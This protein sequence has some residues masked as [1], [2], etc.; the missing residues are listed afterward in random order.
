MMEN[1]S[2]AVTSLTGGIEYLFKK[3]KV[4]YIKGWGKLAGPHSVNVTLNAG[5]VQ[6]VESKNIILA[7]GSEVT[8]LA[9]CP[10]DNAGQQV[11]DS[12]GALVLTKIPK[13]LAVIG[14][15]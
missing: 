12:T 5:G 13:R 15:G 11:V 14:G 3:Y 6:V 4:D 7:V 9:T 1:K 10:V 8:P 2:K